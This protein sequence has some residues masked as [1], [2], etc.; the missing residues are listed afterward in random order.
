MF[1]AQIFPGEELPDPRLMG[2]PNKKKEKSKTE[3]TTASF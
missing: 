3:P 1:D 2:P